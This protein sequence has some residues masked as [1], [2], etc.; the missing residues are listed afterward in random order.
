MADIYLHGRQIE[1]IFE[2]LGE[3]EDDITYSIGWAFANS[4]AFL[5]AFIKKAWPKASN[6]DEAIIRLQEAKRQSGRT[7]IE[8][9][10]NNFHIIIEA[11]RGWSLPDERQ[12]SLYAK[13]LKKDNDQ[14]NLI[15]AMSE[16]SQEY[17]SLHLPEQIQNVPVKHFSW[18]DIALTTKRVRDASHAEKR[19]LEQLRTY[20][21]RIVNMQN[22]ESNMVYVVSLGKD[23]IEKSSITW[24]EVVTKKKRYFHPAQKNWPPSAPNYIGFRYDGKLQ[25][26]HHVAS[27]EIV[28]DLH[29]SIPEI[30]VKAGE[31]GPLYL[32]KLGKPIIPNTEVRTG[33]LFRS[34]RVWAMLDLLLTSNTISEARDLTQKRLSEDE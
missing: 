24:I 11:K 14:Q 5:N 4:P 17:A 30:G 28:E 31:W 1:S 26:I 9:Q 2:L 34:G 13:R 19:L 29:S 23:I 21:R 22:Q 16:C 33:N 8:I 25:S 12:L 7:D 18:K 3:D 32:Y 10:G 6:T 20:L 15:V 27:W